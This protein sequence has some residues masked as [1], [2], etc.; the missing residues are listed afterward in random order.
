M[1]IFKVIASGKK[2]FFEE[3]ASAVLAWLMNPM[4][5]HGMGFEF[6][7]RLIKS[8]PES[9]IVASKLI[10]QLRNDQNQINWTCILEDNVI[11]AFVDIVFILDDLVL[12]IENKI[13][14]NSASDMKQLE[15]EYEGLKHKYPDKRIGVIFLIPLEN[16]DMAKDN[17]QLEFDNLKVNGSDFKLLATW[18]KNSFGNTSVASIIE[19]ILLDEAKGAV[20]PFSEYLRHTL[21]AFINFINDGFSGYYY[22]GYNKNNGDNPNT[23]DHLGVK[24]LKN[25]KTG[26]VGVKNGV[27]GL[28]LGEKQS[29]QIKTFQYTESDMTLMNNWLPIELF[30]K[31]MEWLLEGNK[32]NIQWNYT[33]P[34]EAIYKIVCSYVDEV[35]IGIKGGSASLES[36]DSEIIKSKRWQIKSVNKPITNNWL[37]GTKFK[38]IIDKKNVYGHIYF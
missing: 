35:F 1:N 8:I 16:P 6:L 4:M 28:L 15:R 24:Q 20:A 29:L 37:S 11:S 10:T 12:A 33:L 34:S 9:E 23:Q 21:K 7:S 19:S 14:S 36:M 17:V 5:E 3:Q 18:Q 27:S 26:F 31:I 32:V 30:N 13:Y 2:P 22:D 38:E 25:L